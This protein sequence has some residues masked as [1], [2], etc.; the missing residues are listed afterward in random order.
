MHKTC[1]MFQSQVSF[2]T[3]TCY[4]HGMMFIDMI[5]KDNHNDTHPA[6]HLNG[7]EDT[8]ALRKNIEKQM[9]VSFVNHV[10][11]MNSNAYMPYQR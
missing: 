7:T 2:F 3:V 5:L 4:G 11:I 9:H 1:F 10:L 6:Y 8:Q